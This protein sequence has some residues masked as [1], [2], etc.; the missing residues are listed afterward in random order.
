MV[1]LL[2]NLGT[3]DLMTQVFR[4][5]IHP[6]RIQETQEDTQ[7]AKVINMIACRMDTLCVGQDKTTSIIVL[8]V[9]LPT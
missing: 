1:N 3:R 6:V 2:M 5:S 7:L 4:Y 9:I 8:M